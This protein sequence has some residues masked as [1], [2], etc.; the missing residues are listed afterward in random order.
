[1]HGHQCESLM[2]FQPN[3]YPRVNL[4]MITCVETCKM[5][6]FI[7]FPWNNSF[8]FSQWIWN[9]QS[10][11]FSYASFGFSLITLYYSCIL[12]LEFEIFILVVGY[13]FDSYA[14]LL[15][16]PLKKLV[17]L[18]RVSR[19]WCRLCSG[20]FIEYLSHIFLINNSTPKTIGL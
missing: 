12:F 6:F 8:Q 19:H 5:N 16:Y 18:F 14:I 7:A 2:C 13:E 20:C 10:R 17:F 3:G 11:Q 15:R 9:F 4:L 1:M